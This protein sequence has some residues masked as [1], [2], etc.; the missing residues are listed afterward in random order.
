MSV[1]GIKELASLVNDHLDTFTM[2]ME[3]F[4]PAAFADVLPGPLNSGEFTALIPHSRAQHRPL[5]I[6][7]SLERNRF[8]T[9]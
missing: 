7:R 8:C 9:P 1:S 5:Q 2:L 3:A 4:V 6:T